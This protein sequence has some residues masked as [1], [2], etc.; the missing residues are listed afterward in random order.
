MHAIL[1]REL[2]SPSFALYTTSSA[3]ASQ[4]QLRKAEQMRILPTHTMTV[5]RQMP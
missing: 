3:F 5:G 1:D 4:S 2:Q